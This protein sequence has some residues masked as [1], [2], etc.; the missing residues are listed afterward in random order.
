[1]NVESLPS[2][3]ANVPTRTEK[4]IHRKLDE[5]FHADLDK[6]V[7]DEVEYGKFWLRWVLGLEEHTTKLREPEEKKET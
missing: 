4:E 3:K 6:M 2:V 1:M 7:F 5:L